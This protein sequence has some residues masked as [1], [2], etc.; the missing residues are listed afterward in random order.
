M[1]IDKHLDVINACRFCF[2]CRHVATLGNVTFKESD[3]PRGR[4]LILDKVR[5]DKNH[6]NNLDYIE[7]LYQATL[8]AA[9]RFHC[10]SD[11]D[12]T[13]LVLAARCDIVEA[14]LAP[15]HVNALAKELQQVNF[16][17]EGQGNVLYYRDPYS[18]NADAFTDCKIITGG[19]TGKALEVLGFVKESRAVFAKFK[20]AV[21]SSD[22]KTLVTSCPASYDM[23]KD[24]LTGVTVMHSSQYL[25]KKPLPKKSGKVCYLDSD[26]LKNYNDNLSAPRDLL[27]KC[28]YELVPFGITTEESYAVGEGAVVYDK[29]YPDLTKKLCDRIVELT[30]DA[31]TDVLVTASP[32]TQHALKT[33]APQ[34][35]VLSLEQATRQSQG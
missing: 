6:L 26:F 18:E 22:C 29:L 31:E 2:M 35:N 30:D 1:N 11:Y 10:V 33:F 27:E 17:V 24:K 13:G 12:E 3:T 34:L 14:Q 9:C 32:Y 19:D 23:L 8:S 25:L 5:M 4:A 21:A 20:A 15:E 28:G 7:T 16:T